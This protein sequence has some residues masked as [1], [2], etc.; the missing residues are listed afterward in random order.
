MAGLFGIGD[1]SKAGKG[2][3]K[4]SAKQ[5]SLKLFFEILGTRIWN[6]FR[7]N[8]IY[9][10]ACLP[11]LTIGPATAGMTKV[12]KNY[13]ADKNAFVWMDFKQAFRENFLRAFVMGIIDLVAY[14]GMAS[15]IWL[16]S[17][18]AIY[19]SSQNAGITTEEII[20]YVLLAVTLSAGITFTVMN[21]YI[22]IMM[23]S[24]DLSMKNII[25]NSLALAFL[26]PRKN[27]TAFILSVVIGLI[28][29]GLIWLN[30]QFIIV[31]PF[32]PAAIIGLVVCYLCYPVVQ[33]YVIAP[34]Y[35]E[36]GEQNPEAPAEESSE[37]VLFED[38]GGKEMPAE[39]IKKKAKGKKILS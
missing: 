30:M 25:K 33:K 29:L 22:Y 15:G 1:F 26:A 5:G 7:L 6:L 2:I 35:E 14:F 13:A 16:Y 21:Y 34:Y 38:M 28:P 8:L 31:L 27:L 18:N 23:V 9:V 10:I 32:A 20:Y 24:T 37:E 39:E 3:E 4:N 11:V 17:T 36:T 19:V 12:V